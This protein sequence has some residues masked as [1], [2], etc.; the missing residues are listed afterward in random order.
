MGDLRYGSLGGWCAVAPDGATLLHMEV[1]HVTLRDGRRVDTCAG[2]D[3]AGP[4]V[5]LQHG[6][7]G[8]R[9][10]AAHAD[11]A[12]RACGVRL[13]SLSRPGFGR[14]SPAPPSLA[15][16]GR[17]AVEVAAALGADEFA[18]LG[19]SF[20]APFAAA[21][22]VMGG[23]RVT[24]LGIVVG[25]GPWLELDPIDDPEVA[26]EREIFELDA[27]GRTE[28]A[29]AAYL[30]LAATWLDDVRSKETD[31]ELMQAFDAM[32]APEDGTP[33]EDLGDLGSELRIRFARDVRESLTTYDGVVHDNFAAGRTWDIDLATVQQPTFLWYGEVDK[34]LSL[35]H[36][37]WWQSQIPHAQLTIREGEGHGGTFLRH[38]S[39]MLRQLTA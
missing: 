26:K 25:M 7:P 3:P 38:W 13:L 9:L 39:D 8:S 10:T 16:C 30:A 28:E 29:M 37:R 24:A 6:M 19:I 18:V 17:D 15:A 36:A 20:G 11:E 35:D 27:A 31:E 22:A 23:D 21:T 34:L 14:S 2:G 12:A 4:A 32:T 33:G 5:L 1:G